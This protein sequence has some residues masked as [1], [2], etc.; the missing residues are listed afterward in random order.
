MP[1]PAPPL[2]RTIRDDDRA[3]IAEL[4]YASINTWYRQHGMPPIFVGGP[5]MT[6]VFCDVYNALDPDA[7]VVAINPRTGRMMGSCFFHPRPKHVSLGIMTVHPNY[8]GSGLGS[9][10]LK[11]IT[12]FADR[13]GLPVRLTQS[14][15][16]LDSFSLY[17]KAGFVPRHAFQDM[18]LHV[19]E[20]GMP[21]APAGIDRVRPAT[22][23]DVPAMAALEEEVSGITREHDYRY[24]LANALGIWS[25]LVHENPRGDLDGFMISCGHACTNMLG[26]CVA[27]GDEPA[28]ALIHRALD[29]YRGRM[30][31]FLI[32]MERDRLVRT[33][34]EWGARNCE[35]HF[36]QVRGEF[37][38]F[39]GISMPSFMPETG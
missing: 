7:N 6:E 3:E 10:L 34:Y 13:A 14:A 1:L 11:H 32:P 4:I 16:N 36:C 21:G 27:R 5:H 12:D 23:A 33:M 38:P 25:V 22:P 8:W 9:L 31:V 30:P 35:M 39:R 26:P 28:A 15:L 20:T 18:L 29:L 2:L 24:C 37:Q 19:P 17:N